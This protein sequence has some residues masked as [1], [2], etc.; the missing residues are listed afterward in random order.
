M[1]FPKIAKD[2]QVFDVADH[3]C[4][5]K[6]PSVVPDGRFDIFFWVFN[7]F[8]LKCTEVCYSLVYGVANSEFNVNSRPSLPGHRYWGPFNLSPGIIAKIARCANFYAFF[9]KFWEVLESKCVHSRDARFC[10]VPSDV[11]FFLSPIYK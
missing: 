3:E 4:D 9:A 11:R 7:M 8:S 10:Y 2:W 5:I 6:N 1:R